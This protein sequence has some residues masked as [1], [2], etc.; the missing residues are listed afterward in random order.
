MDT[1]VKYRSDYEYYPPRQMVYQET[2]YHFSH[3]KF[4]VPWQMEEEGKRDKER[5][6]K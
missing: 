1:K 3:E 2:R 6:I 4:V 5:E